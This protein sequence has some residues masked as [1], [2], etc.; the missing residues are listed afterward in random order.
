VK[1]AFFLAIGILFGLG[2]NLGQAQ[3]AAID[4]TQPTL[5]ITQVICS[6]PTLANIDE[7]LAEVYTTTAKAT[8]DQ[9][10][11]A[12][13]EQDWYGGTVLS[14][15]WF[16]ERH[17]PIDGEKLLEAYERHMDTLRQEAT[18]WQA[19]RISMTADQLATTCVILPPFSHDA[20]CRVTA[21]QPVTGDPSLRYQFQSFS[22]DNP[23]GVV[24]VFQAQ[25][26]SGNRFMPLVA[27]SAQRDGK[28]PRYQLPAAMN[29][30]DGRFLIVAG[31]FAEGDPTSLFVL[32]RYGEGIARIIDTDSWV[33]DLQR[34]LPKDLVPS[35]IAIDYVTMTAKITLQR[36]SG[37]AGGYAT[38][39]L[40]ID[41][42]RLTIR[43]MKLEATPS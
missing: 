42:D 15:N 24:V 28:P 12:D 13:A 32:Y 17:L 27:G 30:P 10:S 9:P 38:I 35:D 25:D 16:A 20:P 11:L 7:A 43:D 33:R 5:P 26:D 40:K 4:C 6:N 23:A 18:A 36:R 19:V 21:F 39:A 41:G 37:L 1:A 34:R 14:N 22:N 3:A 8:L 2:P 31:T 29:A